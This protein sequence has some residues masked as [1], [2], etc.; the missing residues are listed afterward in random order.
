MR[1]ES[2]RGRNILECHCR[3]T[4]TLGQCDMLWMLFFPTKLLNRQTKAALFS[5]DVQKGKNL[6][7]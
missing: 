2:G 3:G 6:S 1:P 5:P 4:C 7:F